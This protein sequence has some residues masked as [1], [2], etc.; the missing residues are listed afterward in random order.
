M[1]CLIAWRFGLDDAVPLHDVDLLA[2]ETNKSLTARETRRGL[3]NSIISTCF[4]RIAAR[5]EVWRMRH[6]PPLVSGKIDHRRSMILHHAC[7]RASTLKGQ[8][9]VRRAGRVRCVVTRLEGYEWLRG[10]GSGSRGFV[11]A[12]CRSPLLRLRNATVWRSF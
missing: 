11:S 7:T 2:P 4:T 12:R 1:T 10:I 5:D 3:P 9:Q 6:S 8:T